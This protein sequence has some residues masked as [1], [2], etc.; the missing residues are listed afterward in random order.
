MSCTAVSSV[1][2]E[3]GAFPGSVVD[4]LPGKVELQGPAPLS[5]A[6]SED[7]SGAC[8]VQMADWSSIVSHV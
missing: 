4:V 1:V 2:Q 3:Q 7:V 6:L 5:P 8:D